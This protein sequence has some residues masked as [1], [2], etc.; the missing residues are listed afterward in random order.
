MAFKRGQ[1]IR[2]KD[3][4]GIVTGTSLGVKDGSIITLVN[5]DS[6][7]ENGLTVNSIS[8]V[9]ETSITPAALDD[10]PAARRG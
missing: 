1:W 2:H 10:I 4:I 7:D 5:Y 8:S 6:V 3:V 9:P